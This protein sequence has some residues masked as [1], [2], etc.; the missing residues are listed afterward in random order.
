MTD[1]ALSDDDSNENT[2]GDANTN[3]TAGMDNDR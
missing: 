2:G 1:T 3:D